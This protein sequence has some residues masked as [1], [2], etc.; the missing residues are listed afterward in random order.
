MWVRMNANPG[1][2]NVGDCVVRAISA[3]TGMSWLDVYDALHMEGRA[4]YDMP[5]SN[6]VWGRYL[7]R[8]GF[9]P[10]FLPESC[11]KCLTIREFAKRYPRG[12]YVIG[13]GT[14]AVAVIDGDYF[15]TFDSGELVPSYYFKV[16]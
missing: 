5:S 3:A 4:F 2:R 12:R 9:Q 1:R 7:Y 15:D 8:L 13:T 6:E 11:P 16:R 10:F 14:H